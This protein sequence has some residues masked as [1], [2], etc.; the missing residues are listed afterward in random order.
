MQIHR[1]DCSAEK[2][3][4]RFIELICSCSDSIRNQHRTQSLS[5]LSKQMSRIARVVLSQARLAT[6]ISSPALARS[7]CIPR[8][9]LL[10][11]ARPAPLCSSRRSF[12]SPP[13]SKAGLISTQPSPDGNGTI[14]VVLIQDAKKI[15]NEFDAIV[16]V[17][18]ANE[19]AEGMIPGAMHIPL[20]Q[21]LENPK[22]AK[23]AGK[24]QVLVYCRAGIRSAKA[25]AALQGAGTKAVNLGG[26]YMAYTGD[27]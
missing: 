23:L 2:R 9:S 19:V 8:P 13:G 10:L 11:S 16:D 12:F 21:V 14:P 1:A 25:V 24:K 7:V 5:P 6:R 3:Q 27:K 26:G 15:W 22:Q 18:E 20:G 4:R 17:R